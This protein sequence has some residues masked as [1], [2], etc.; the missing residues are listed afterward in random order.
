MKLAS[1]EQTYTVNLT[2]D[3]METILTALEV[4]LGIVVEDDFVPV[5]K[6]YKRVSVE[7]DVQAYN[8]LADAYGVD[9]YTVSEFI[10]E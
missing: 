2:R 7:R 6:Q 3:E 10:E 9:K 8:T 4:D 5:E 1:R